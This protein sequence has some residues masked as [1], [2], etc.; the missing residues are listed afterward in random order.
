MNSLNQKRQVKKAANRENTRLSKL[1]RILSVLA[2]LSFLVFSVCAV[3]YV[4]FFRTVLA[5][6]I[7]QD[8]NNELVF[9]EP[10]ASPREAGVTAKVVVGKVIEVEEERGAVKRPE[11]PKVAIIIDDL[12]YDEAI[13][14]QLLKFPIELTYSFLP[15]APYTRKLERLAHRAGKTVFLHLPLEPKDSSFNPGPGGLYLHDSPETQRE[16][17]ARCLREVPHAVGLNNHMGS[18]FT[19]DRLA[20]DNIMEMI[21]GRSLTFVDSYTTPKSVGLQAARQATVEN[22]G[23]SV[24]LDNEVDE[25]KICDQLELLVI[26]SEKHGRVVG[27]GHP[28]RT[29]VNALL[30]C[31]EK[32]RTR[33]EY[34][35]VLDLFL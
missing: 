26:L 31:G 25:D 18:A 29:T 6:E 15:F 21:K 35:D 4:V 10:A 9:E 24:F 16:K 13:G 23:R 30:R 12:G 32:Y 19:E 5:Q 8:N 11:L 34:V 1:A 20:M 3:G 17:L 14:L 33:V 22:I 2:L 27:I 7:P 28:R